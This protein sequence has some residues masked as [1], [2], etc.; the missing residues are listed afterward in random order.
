MLIT[1]IVVII[2]GYQKTFILTGVNHS[3]KMVNGEFGGMIYSSENHLGHALGVNQ[4]IGKRSYH[5]ES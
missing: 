4:N 2:C 3:E 5:A 1:V